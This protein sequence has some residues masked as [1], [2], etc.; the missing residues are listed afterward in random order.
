[1]Q[2]SSYLKNRVAPQ[3]NGHV[4]MILEAKRLFL[5]Q[6]VRALYARADPAVLWQLLLKYRKE[7]AFVEMG[8]DNSAAVDDLRI[9][10][11][12]FRSA[13]Y[14]LL[15]GG[16]GGISSAAPESELQK[17][18]IFFEHP[19]LSPATFLA[20]EA[21]ASGT[22]SVLPLYTFVA[23][24]LLLFRLRVELEISATVP[25]SIQTR[26]LRR[27]GGV[28]AAVANSVTSPLSNHLTAEDL[29]NFMASLIPNLRL[30]R[31]MPP[32]LLP[33]YLCHASRKFFA[34]LDPRGL[35][36]LSI[37]TVMRSEIFSELLRLYESDPLDA[38]VAFPPGCLVEVPASRLS[39]ASRSGADVLVSGEEEELVQVVVED[40]EGDGNRLGDSYRVRSAPSSSARAGD[41][42]TTVFQVPRAC[43]FWCPAT[44]SALSAD[45]LMLDNWFSLP[46]MFRV[47]TH[48]TQLDVDGDG[49]L[50]EEEFR[51]YS[52]S[53]Y[54]PLA[55]HRVFECYIPAPS[56]P[57]T[58]T[59]E[60]QQGDDKSENNDDVPPSPN[61]TVMAAMDFKAYL[62]FVVAT[63]H[64]HV[65]A[66]VRYLWRLLDVEDTRE[67]ISVAA[68]RCFTREV[69]HMLVSAGLT[70]EVHPI[71]STSILTEVVDMIN[72]ECHERVTLRD[73]E[74]C[75]QQAT[76]LLI[77]LNY[78]SF[79]A[80]DCREQSA[81]ESREE[82]V[83]PL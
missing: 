17:K 23:K 34:L 40:Y 66:A 36:V 3:H 39:S 53:S 47:Y 25:P 68:L 62:N 51:R 35:G 54:T 10:F 46:L 59:D 14:E 22:I 52:G 28:Q 15:W 42:D 56:G 65:P 48:F 6:H 12:G 26:H 73:L 50:T 60:Q 8:E 32:W 27:E 83:S 77:L 24:R 19:F 61:P 71:S 70:S 78:K 72:P 69:S 7:E 44:S 74:S 30:V 67:Y 20:F 75:K 38:T 9:S 49:V 43:C 31:D 64:P 41:T 79:Y 80:Y 76:V 33:Y 1:M 37:D 82:F 21:D 29:E 2:F 81:A 11:E 16:D 18:L 57:L 13:V 58:A 45:A 5:R 55:A 4:A 63:E